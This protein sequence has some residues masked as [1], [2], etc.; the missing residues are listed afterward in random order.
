MFVDSHCHIDGAEYDADRAEVIA[1]AGAAGVEAI[2]VIGTGNPQ[3][4]EPE[5]ALELAES[6]SPIESRET[7]NSPRL[8]ASIGVHP[9]DARL[10]DENFAARLE[11]L[12]R[13]RELLVAVGEIGLDYHYDNSPR[14]VQ[15]E[16]FALQLRIAR[17]LDLPVI[18]H[19]RE[20]ESHTMEILEAELKG[21]SRAGGCGVM[22]CFS[23]GEEMAERALK[24]NLLISFAGNLTFRKAEELHAVAK[25]L[26]LDRLLIETDAPYLAPVPHRGRRNEPAYVV[27]VAR[28]LAALYNVDVEQVA[29]HTTENFY[30]LF[31]RASL[32][33]K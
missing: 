31:G 7:V 22:H 3:Q 13:T 16:V 8:F 4:R 1:R 21:Y 12:L 30:K 33:E 14:D 29:R 32:N 28:S 9:H 25:S 11:E 5:R 19:T 10:F 23:G 26:P 27:E 2:L 18:I 24:L 20:A 17:E 15:Q 6:C